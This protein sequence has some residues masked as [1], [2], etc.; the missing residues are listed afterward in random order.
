[1][2]VPLCIPHDTRT[3]A[4]ETGLNDA[5]VTSIDWRQFE[6]W[7]QF[8]NSTIDAHGYPHRGHVLDWV[9]DA[10]STDAKPAV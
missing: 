8:D 7:R 9:F 10:I 3:V 4:D 2:G 1:M 5:Y 6:D